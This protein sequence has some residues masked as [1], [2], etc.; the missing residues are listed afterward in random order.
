ML[1]VKKGGESHPISVDIHLQACVVESILAKIC[2][3][4]LG[5]KD[6]PGVR[7]EEKLKTKEKRKDK[8]I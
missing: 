5:T 2:T 8:A 6:Q 3:S 1:R 4:I 7:K